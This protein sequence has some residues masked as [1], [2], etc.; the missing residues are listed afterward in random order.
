MRAAQ[1]KS[2]F[3]NRNSNEKFCQHNGGLRRGTLASPWNQSRELGPH[4]ARRVKGR[5]IP[6]DR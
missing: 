5:R 6:K 4:S 1:S 3:V 2:H